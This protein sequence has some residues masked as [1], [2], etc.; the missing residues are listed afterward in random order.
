L[1]VAAT[2]KNN[3][4][5]ALF[6]TAREDVITFIKQLAHDE[7]NTDGWPA[8]RFASVFDTLPELK[9]LASTP[10]MLRIATDI[11]GNLAMRKTSAN[12]IKGSL[13][14]LAK[15]NYG[16]DVLNSI[17]G[18]KDIEATQALVDRV[19]EEKTID[20]KDKKKVQEI[21]RLVQDLTT[22]Y[23]V[24][25]LGK[26]TKEKHYFQ[27][28]GETY[29]DVDLW[30]VTLPQRCSV[31]DLYADNLEGLDAKR[32]KY[33]N[34]LLASLEELPRHV[35]DL[36]W[37]WLKRN[38]V[39]EKEVLEE[40]RQNFLPYLK[41]FYN[42]DG[43]PGSVFSTFRKVSRAL[44]NW[45]STLPKTVLEQLATIGKIGQ[46]TVLKHHGQMG[47]HIETWTLSGN[48]WKLPKQ[49]YPPSLKGL[50]I[51]TCSFFLCRCFWGAQL[52]S[53]FF[54]FFSQRF[55]E[56]GQ[57]HVSGVQRNRGNMPA[58]N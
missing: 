39:V 27:H 35:T 26:P 16:A 44:N 23:V 43:L 37:G 22:R 29:C 54:L 32:Q 50:Q 33:Q 53:F 21:K 14:A 55:K 38:C 5:A 28:P 51:G 25:V 30:T 46:P 11:L 13:I 4:G 12:D 47:E 49:S 45:E 48:Q 2:P 9:E 34:K 42:S 7:Q 19:L 40:L 58:S 24:E 8:A 56:L 6:T 15:E 20:E 31:N 17:S 57:V 3:D 52:T 10:F 1:L 36:C 41:V 18:C